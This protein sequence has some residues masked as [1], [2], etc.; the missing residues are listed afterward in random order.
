MFVKLGLAR[1]IRFAAG[2]KPWSLH[3]PGGED[4]QT[5]AADA[6]KKYPGVVLERRPTDEQAGVLRL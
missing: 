6:I 3:S 1:S 5:G 2:S 4:G